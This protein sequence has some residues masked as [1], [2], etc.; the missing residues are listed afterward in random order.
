VA[1]IVHAHGGT[2]TVTDASGLGGARI[3]VVLPA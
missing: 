3:E 1:D 2:V